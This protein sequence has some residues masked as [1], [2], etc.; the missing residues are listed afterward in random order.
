MEAKSPFQSK[1]FLAFLIV[2]ITWK[3]L[4]GMV[5]F[6]GKGSMDKDTFI[7]LL[8]VIVTAGVV[9]VGYILGQAALDKY[10][11]MAITAIKRGSDDGEET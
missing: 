9:E 2:E 8:A 4:A 10:I 5:L 11:H 1:K 6:W 3:I 7:V